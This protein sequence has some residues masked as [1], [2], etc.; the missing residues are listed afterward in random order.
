MTDLVDDGARSWRLGAMIFSLFG[1]LAVVLA[2]VGLYAL[3]AF[4]VRRRTAEIGVRMARGASPA[5]VARLVPGQGAKI[6]VIGWLIGA[7]AALVVAGGIRGLPFSV[8][9]F[10]PT[11]FVVSSLVTV[12]AGLAGSA[13]TAL[14]AARLDPVVALGSD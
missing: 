6:V 11:T 5:S 14:V 7:A 3:L 1:A 8:Q 13:L 2:A 10:D 12:L 9:P 4:A